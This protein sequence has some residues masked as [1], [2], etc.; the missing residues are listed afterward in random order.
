MRFQLKPQAYALRR[1][2]GTARFSSDSSS[3]R[4]CGWQ[5]EKTVPLAKVRSSKAKKCS[6][7]SQMN[8]MR[9][10]VGGEAD[11]MRS[12][13]AESDFLAESGVVV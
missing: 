5:S 4:G 13:G 3:S 8:S 11:Q 10:V 2:M 1:F 6:V 7:A 9:V 12:G